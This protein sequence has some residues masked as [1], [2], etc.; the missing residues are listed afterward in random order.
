MNVNKFQEKIVINVRQILIAID[1]LI[2]L[3]A[4]KE[5]AIHV[6]RI[7]IV[8]MGINVILKQGNVSYKLNK[9]LNLPFKQLKPYKVQVM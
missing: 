9:L 7:L 2:V 6:F 4:K 8:K 1:I 5:Y 3:H